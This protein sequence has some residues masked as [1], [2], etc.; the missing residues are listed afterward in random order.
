M[1]YSLRVPLLA[2]QGFEQDAGDTWSMTLSTPACNISGDIWDYETSLSAIS[3]S[4]GNQFWGMQD[5]EGNCGGAGYETITFASTAIT[6]YTSVSISFDYYTIGYES[7][8]NLGYEIWE[9]GTQVVDDVGLNDNTGGWVTI[10]HNVTPGTSNV[11]LILKAKQN[12]GSDYAGFDNVILEGT[13]TS[14][15]SISTSAISGSPFCV[16]NGFTASVSVSYTITGSF[17]ATNDF[18]AE[19]SDASGSFA[20][21]ITI[22]TLSNTNADGTIAA[23]IP[24]SV[25]AGAGYRIRVVGNDPSTIGADNGSDLM[26]NNFEAPTGIVASCGNAEGAVSWT[27]PGCFDEVMVVVSSSS[28]TASLPTGDGSAYSPNTVFGSGTAHDGG[29]VV[30]K[31]TGTSTGTITG[32]TNGTTY[33]FK[34]FVRKGTTWLSGGADNCTPIS[35]CINESFSNLGPYGGYQTETWT[36]DDGGTWTATDARTDQNINGSAI[37]IR[38]GVLTSPISAG[39]IGSLTVTTQRVFSGGSGNLDVRVNG[40]SVGS[41]PYDGTVQTTT[42]SNIDLAGNVQIEIDATNSSSDRVAI[43]DLSWTCFAAP[44]IM[45]SP[46]VLSGFVYTE[47]FGPSGV[48]SFT[49]SGIDL[50]DD[51]VITAPTNYEISLSNAPFASASPITLTQSGGIVNST[52]VYVRLAAGLSV[53][54]YNGENIASTSTGATTQNVI[55]SG[56]V[57]SAQTI[58]TGVVVGSP[59]CVGNGA[60]ASVNVPFTIT[61]T[62]NGTNTFTAQLSDASGSFAAPV[63]IGSLSS[64]TSGTISATVPT[65][66]GAGTGYRIRVV[67]DDPAIIGTD[68]GTD[69][70]VQGFAAPTGLS[71]ICSSEF[72]DLSWINPDC[73][74]EVMV[75]ASSSVFTTA[76]PVGDGSAYTASLTFG[77]GTAFDGGHVI[78]K[79]TGAASG[80]VTSLTNGTAYN[81]KVFARSGTTWIAG[82]TESCTPETDIFI[83]EYLEGS[84]NNKAIEIYNGTGGP[85]DLSNYELRLYSNGSSTVS[86]TISLSGTLNN[87][88]VYVVA[89]IGADAAITSVADQ[90]TGSLNFNGDDAVVLYN[91]STSSYADIVGNIGCDPGA[92]LSSGGFSTEDMTLVRKV[93]V[94]QGVDTDP[95]ASCPFP[96]LTTEWLQYATDDV[97]YLGSHSGCNQTLSITTGSVSSPPFALSSCTDTETGTVA[98]TSSG[99][100]NTGNVYSVQLSNENGDFS[101]PTTIG[102]ITSTANSGNISITIPAGTAAGTGY[103]VR[104]VSSDPDVFGSQSTSFSITSG[105]TAQV[106]E[107][108]DLAILAFNTNVD[109]TF[110]YDE[111]SFVSFVDIL[112]GTYIDF[113]DNAFQKC[114]TPNG[115]G[116]SEGWFRL[117]RTTNTLPKGEVVTVQVAYGNA[118]VIAPDNN[119]TSSKPQ[120]LGQGNFDLNADGEQMF[121]LSGGNVGGPGATTPNSDAGTYTGDIL[122]GFNTKGNIW[123]PV[124]DNAAAGGTKNS[125]KPVDFDC[126]LVWPT[127]QADKN[128]YSGPMT[129]ASQGDWLYRI[130]TSSNWTGYADNTNYEAGPDFIDF[131]GPNA[132]RTIVISSGGFSSGLW[133]GEDDDNWHNC[134]NWQSLRVPDN[135]TDVEVPDS[136]NDPRI[137]APN[138][139]DCNTIHIQTDNG[140]VLRIEDT[141]KLRVHQP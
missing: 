96:T 107:A 40:V 26:I 29:F 37:C 23:T 31:G 18:T 80:T 100:F 63:A 90:A 62:F 49:V 136:P 44:V 89:N 17:A 33:Y 1:A 86:S 14:S 103:K 87:S 73:F 141:A 48:Q 71:A 119:W 92:V 12:G 25:G 112:P 109:G 70:E 52:T 66:V 83:S 16:G 22:G 38:D 114:G 55:C 102:T 115:W 104:V 95:T 88:N 43:D 13:A 68:N 128:K 76:V 51:I 93:T 57:I 82:S 126:F 24:A 61:G 56:D 94:C 139:G 6:A 121:L 74:D 46:T 117:T 132:G 120:P 53:G 20:S 34:V 54:G 15:E 67:S 137:L 4:A 41:V 84:G 39:G 9:D 75:V 133:T 140:A 36:G 98:F 59:F 2:Y 134:R 129:P 28:F 110:G 127:A 131:N 10:T 58:A 118:S 64:A 72:A 35:V 27:N 116:I 8:D 32:L 91:N 19:L 65:S 79:G 130:N 125:D 138:V 81:F 135:A 30:Y 45:V 5:I 85:V 99:T 111:I 60:T 7:A 77:V 97:S 47:G 3:P 11:Y 108:G 69:L 122:Y 50:V 113:T 124:C 42:I 101:T 78:Y 123:T 21:P 105:C 106:I